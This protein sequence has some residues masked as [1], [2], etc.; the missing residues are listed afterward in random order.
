MKRYTMQTLTAAACCSLLAITACSNSTGPGV[1][2]ASVVL[3]GD[4]ASAN[5]VGAGIGLNVAGVP[6]SAVANLFLTITRVDLHLVGSGGEGE[7]EGGEGESSEGGEGEA[8]ES[9]WITLDVTLTEPVDV[10]GLSTAGLELAA[11][12][13]PAGRY[14]QARFFFDTSELVLGEQVVSNGATLDPGSYDVNVPSAA[15]TGL[16]LQLSSTD[17]GDGDTETV[18]VEIGTGTTIGTLVW[19]ANGF[20]VSPH[21][22]EN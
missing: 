22:K 9:G 19:N 16:K 5:L 6:E 13:V 7:S 4:A 10:L 12:T 21:L 20:A 2:Q 8:S 1:G 15:Q 11:G 18:G 17:V 14:N 3:M